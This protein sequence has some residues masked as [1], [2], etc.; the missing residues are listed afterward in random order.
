MQKFYSLQELSIHVGGTLVGDA[1]LAIKGVNTLNNA[2]ADQ[3]SFLA[4][5]KYKS[6]LKD[7]SA[8]AVLLTEQAAADYQ[9]NAIVLKDPYVGYARIAQ[10]LDTT[11]AAAT[12]IHPSA[13]IDPS[14]QLAEGVAVGA[15]AVI[16]ANVQ[17]AAGVQV[18]PGT[19]VGQGCKIGE[20]TV[21]RANVTLYHDVVIGANSTVHSATVIGADGFGYANEM[22]NWIKIPQLGSVH[23]GDNVEIGASTTID[24]G[25][26]EHTIIEDG[27]IIDNQVQ[28]AH[29]VIIGQNTAI[30]G[31]TTI[32][33]S[34]KI[35]K[36]CI[37]GG[38][39]AINGHIE[40]ADKVHITGRTMVMGNI[41][42]PGVYSSGTPHM[43]NKDWRKNAARFRQLNEL[44]TKV[45]RIEQSIQSDDE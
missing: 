16:E 3:I 19:V 12:A 2:Q 4:N 41:T 10:L 23:I 11:P 22:G 20:N 32:A 14:A 38:T 34:T 45:K 35:G 6:Q 30:A 7:T 29:N 18:G 28:I 25:A 33:G 43:A 21:L 27:V 9:G 24:R 26:L 42:E 8:G 31:C 17:L 13:F 44:F 37:L 1:D 36:Y 40:I 5:A 15:N 39:V